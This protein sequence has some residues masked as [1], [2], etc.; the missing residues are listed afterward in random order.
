MSYAGTGARE[1]ARLAARIVTDRLRG[2]GVAEDDLRADLI[3]VDS[4]HGAGISGD[5][6]PYEV[7]IRVAAR[8]S[9]L[10]GARRIG[11]E[12]EALYTNGPAG[13]AGASRSVRDV[14]SV[15][16]TLVPRTLVRCDV[17]CEAT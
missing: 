15:A 6:E 8:A 10:E 9:S 2:T 7:R 14:L 16:S 5:R 11:R 4:M 3:G 1:R 13:G 17:Q 12:V